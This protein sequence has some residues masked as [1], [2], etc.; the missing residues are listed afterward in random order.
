MDLLLWNAALLALVILA[1][2]LILE[3]DVQ[4]FEL[5]VEEGIWRDDLGNALLTRDLIAENR[6]GNVVYQ[7]VEKCVDAFVLKTEQFEFFLN[8]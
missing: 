6:L 8:F 1:F 2:I 3:N 4:V 7:Y 5:A